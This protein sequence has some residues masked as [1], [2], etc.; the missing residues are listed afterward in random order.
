MAIFG[1]SGVGK[2]TLI[3]NMALADIENGN[4]LTV[5]DP[6]GSL[7]EDLL[8]SIPRHRTNDVIYLNPADPKRVIGAHSTHRDQS[9]HAIV[10]TGTMAS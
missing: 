8:D 6:H 9:V 2:T 7:V 3:R 10:I 4:G 1:K 5:I